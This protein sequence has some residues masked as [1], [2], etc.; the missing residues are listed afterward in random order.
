MFGSKP[1]SY[2]PTGFSQDDLQPQRRGFQQ[3]DRVV[4][5]QRENMF[6]PSGKSIFM[7]R[8]EYSEMLNRNSDTMFVRVEHLFTCELDGREL[9]TLDDCVTKLKRL[10]SKG[11][12]WPQ[13]MIME[14]QRGYLVLND[15]ETKAELESFPL[16]WITK[17][18]AVLDSCAYNS[19]LILTVEERNKRLDQIYMFQCEETEADVLKADLDKAV[20]ADFADEK[21]RKSISS[22]ATDT[23]TESNGKQR[24]PEFPRQPYEREY[25]PPPPDILPTSQ[26]RES[27]VVEPIYSKMTDAKRKKCFFPPPL[28]IYSPPVSRPHSVASEARSEVYSPEEKID[29][30]MNTEI[31]NHVIADFEIFLEKISKAAKGTPAEV[32][33]KNMMGLTKKS[34]KLPVVLL[35]STEEYISALQKIKYGI[36]LLGLVDGALSNPSAPEFVHIFFNTLAMVTPLYPAEIPPKVVSP[37]LTV[38]ALRLLADVLNAEEDRL[39]RSLGDSW[40]LPRSRWAEDVPPYIPNFYDGWKPSPPRHRSVESPLYQSPLSRNASQRYSLGPPVQEEPVSNGHVSPPPTY[41]GDPLIRVTYDFVARNNREL[42]VMKGEMVQVIQKS[43]QWWLIRNQLGDE[44]NVPQRV[45]ETVR[46]NG[47]AADSPPTS[48][49]VGSPPTLDMTSSSP[50][51]KAWLEYKGFSRITVNTLGVLTG[52]LLLGMTKDEIRTVCPEEGGKVFFQLQAV[53]SSIALSNESFGMRGGH[54]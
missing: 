5:L 21:P 18:K 19:L 6:R 2:I 29:I 34:K 47:L 22:Q 51:V 31:F 12:L 49:G 8:R 35:P 9:K 23:N 40:N 10:D 28:D 24:P 54:Y 17:T 4:S 14:L 50:Q 25:T 45:L 7:Q 1:F 16:S 41:I 52:K 48:R 27:R 53:K 13:E 11:R 30:E 32:K 37:L 3:D 43:K 38:A 33:K 26:W 42:T 46:S 44:G 36:N 20:K 15:I 39:W